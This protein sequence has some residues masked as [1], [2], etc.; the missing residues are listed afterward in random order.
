MK[1][2]LPYSQ[3]SPMENEIKAKLAEKKE[4][5][6]DPDRYNPITNPIPW[7]N[8]NPYINREKNKASVQRSTGLVI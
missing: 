1:V 4:L 8:H 6:V 3:Q 5:A 2:I 7:M